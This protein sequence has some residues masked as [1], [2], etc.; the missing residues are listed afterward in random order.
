MGRRKN[1]EDTLAH[2]TPDNLIL[3]LGGCPLSGMTGDSEQ[4]LLDYLGFGQAG[5]SQ[6]ANRHD[7]AH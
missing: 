7:G 2:R 5:G 1:F 3:D 6:R 4:K